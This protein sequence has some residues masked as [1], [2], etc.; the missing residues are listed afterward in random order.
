MAPGKEIGRGLLVP[1]IYM[2]MAERPGFVVAGGSSLG[3][4]GLG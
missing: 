4:C 1:D 2:V 3:C